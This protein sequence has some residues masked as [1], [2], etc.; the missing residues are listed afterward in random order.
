MSVGVL[1]AV[2]HMSVR[3]PP[4][5]MLIERMLGRRPTMFFSVG[6]LRMQR[7]E[8]LKLARLVQHIENE[9]PAVAT[10]LEVLSAMVRFSQAQG[11]WLKVASGAKAECL[12]GTS[13][14]SLCIA[15]T[16]VLAECG[17]FVGYSAVLVAGHAPR[18]A[19]LLSFEIDPVHVVIARHVA[20]IALPGA[21]VSFKIGRAGD[22]M[23]TLVEDSG[24]CMVRF[25]FMDH[26]NT[27]FH[28]ELSALERLGACAVTGRVLADNVLKPGAP[29]YLWQTKGAVG[30]TWALCEFRQEDQE[31]WMATVSVGCQIPLAST[32]QAQR[33]LGVH[34]DDPF[35]WRWSWGRRHRQH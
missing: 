11:S 31:D 17:A 7:E 15:G 16:P 19:R 24:E 28:E 23:P 21:D 35:T 12:Q 5:E 8:Y 32:P 22:L 26:S 27:H 29:L 14:V 20:S 13:D 4:I 2:M 10:P 3:Y 30:V 6:L 33:D 18:G 9:V 34:I 25:M 1:L